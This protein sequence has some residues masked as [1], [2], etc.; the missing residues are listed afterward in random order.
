M[1]FQAF[2]SR[3]NDYDEG[4]GDDEEVSEDDTDYFDTTLVS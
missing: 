1:H 2:Y 3:L 4:S